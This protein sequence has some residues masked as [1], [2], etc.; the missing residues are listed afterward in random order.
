MKIILIVCEKLLFFH[1]S[2]A[3]YSDYFS[4][5]QIFQMHSLTMLERKQTQKSNIVMAAN[6]PLNKGLPQ[7][8]NL[9][10]IILLKNQHHSSSKILS[11]IFLGL[12]QLLG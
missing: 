9:L 3:F 4:L 1:L 11:D 12:C 2:L 7:H 10:K 8:K 5:C 6:V